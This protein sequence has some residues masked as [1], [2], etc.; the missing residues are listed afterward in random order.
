MIPIIFA[1]IA[2][3]AAAGAGA[4]ALKWD[5]IIKYLKGKKLAVLGERKVGKTTLIK[6]LTEGSIPEEYEATNDPRRVSGRRFQLRDL[7]LTIQDTRDV[8]GRRGYVWEKI[9]KDADI[10]L[11][12]LRV[13]RLM[14]G[15]RPTE[16]RVQKDI[17]QIKRWLAD[18]P[19]DF[20]L[21]MIGT[22]CDLT[23]PDL[24]ALSPDQIGDYEDNV[25]KMAIFQHIELLGGGESKVTLMLGS[26]K[27]EATTEALV[28]RLFKRIEEEI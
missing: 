9:V 20:P 10:V 18:N 19:K 15:H 2:V 6:F 28:Y 16:S 14:E 5:S 11:Y 3:V 21:F 12:L 23:D 17:G 25:R 24:T 13:D 22:H 26:L 8:P 4:V 7:E 1:V 27:T